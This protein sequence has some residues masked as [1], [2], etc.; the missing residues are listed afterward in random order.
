MTDFSM[1]YG[2]MLSFADEIAR[3]QEDFA[4]VCS[5]LDELVGSLEGKWTG[6]AQVEFAAAYRELKPK[7]VTIG[8]VLEAYATAIK[9]A[10]EAEENADTQ[11]AYETQSLAF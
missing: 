7:L 11:K 5:S 1:G 4:Q 10:A 9:Q 3:T 6:K 2:P 8:S